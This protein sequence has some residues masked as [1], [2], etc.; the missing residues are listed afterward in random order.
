MCYAKKKLPYFFSCH[1]KGK[2]RQLLLSR[3]IKLLEKQDQAETRAGRTPKSFLSPTLTLG[4]FFFSLWVNVERLVK[5]VGY[6]VQGGVPVGD[7]GDPAAENPVEA[8]EEQGA[9]QHGQ[10]H[11]D[12]GGENMG[13]F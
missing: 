6:D 7:P 8:G 12:P 10:H 5:Q 2:S 9:D 1:E 3:I 11:A 4:A 13:F